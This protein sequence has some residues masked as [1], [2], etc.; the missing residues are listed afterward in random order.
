M[1]V[2]PEQPQK[3][4]CGTIYQVAHL[5][6]VVQDPCG[7]PAR[8]RAGPFAGRLDGCPSL[9]PAGGGHHADLLRRGVSGGGKPPR[10][11][12]GGKA[13]AHHLSRCPDRGRVAGAGAGAGHKPQRRNHHWRPAA[14]HEPQRGQPLHLLFGHSR[15]G[16]RF[17]AEGGQIFSRRRRVWRRRN[18]GAGHRLRGGVCHLAGGHS[19]FDELCAQP[20]F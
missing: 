19:L 20:R 6:L 15:Y 2:Y 11:P 3:H 12:A 13:G 5:P 9:H 18:A 17:G 14:G 1:A 8:R 4:R 7:Q 16:G 10:R